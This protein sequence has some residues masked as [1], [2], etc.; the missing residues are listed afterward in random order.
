MFN[1]NFHKYVFIVIFKSKRK[2]FIHNTDL[3]FFLLNSYF[4]IKYKI[5]MH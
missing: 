1:I 5:N 2:I 3:R 4:K